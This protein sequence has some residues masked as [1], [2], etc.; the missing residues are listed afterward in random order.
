MWNPF[1]YSVDPNMTPE[2]LAYKRALNANAGAGLGSADYAGSGLIQMLTGLKLGAQNKKMNEVEQTGREGAQAAISGLYQPLQIGGPS[3]YQP[4]ILP[5]PVDPNSP[6]GIAGDAMVAI[7]KMPDFGAVEGQY[8]LP[9]GYLQEVAQ[10]ESGMDPSAQN[11]KS[12]AGGLFQFI[13]S[14]AKQYGL[15]DKMDPVAATDAAARLAADNAKALRAA[16]GREPTKGELYLAHQQGAGGAIA[17]LSN[18]NALAT[19]VVGADAVNLNGGNSTMTAGDFAQKWTGKL[20]GNTPQQVTG[21]IPTAQIYEALAN[22]WLSPDERQMLTGMIDTQQRAPMEA[23][24]VQQGL[25]DLQ[26]GQTQLDAMGQPQPQQ[27]PAAFQSLDLQAQAAGYAPGSPEYQEFMRNGG[28]SGTPAAFTALD[29]QAQAAGLVPGTPEYQTFMATRGAG[30]IAAAKAEGEDKAA[31][32]SL[33]SKMGGLEQVVSQL[34]E[35]ADK[36]TYTYA[37]QAVDAIGKQFGFEPRE[38]ALARAEY[39]AMVDNQV[40]PLLRETFGAAFTVKEGETL[41]ATLGNPNASPAEKKAILRAFIE[42]KRRDVEGLTKRTAPDALP[43]NS[44]P[45]ADPLGLFQ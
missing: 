30:L 11:P 44:A 10:I 36:A 9:Q 4:G 43:E 29:L 33:S 8:G 22:P 1:N 19:S 35:L 2:Q 18:P 25:Q 38:A 3:P 21:Q 5:A 39:I 16:L 27:L 23:I 41:R 7:G 15:T 37:G 45:S 32:D 28:G 13:D 31:L 17:L 40:L 14:T 20:S 24:Q 42:Q 12:S 6:Q 26:I 34:D